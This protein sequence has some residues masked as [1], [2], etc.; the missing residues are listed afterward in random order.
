M[1]SRWIF[2]VSLL[3]LSMHVRAAEKDAVWLPEYVKSATV[4]SVNGYTMSFVPP[5][6]GHELIGFA[7]VEPVRAG[8]DPCYGGIRFVN[9]GDRVAPVLAPMVNAPLKQHRVLRHPATNKFLGVELRAEAC[10]QVKVETGPDELP[11][12]GIRESCSLTRVN[13]TSRG[14]M[15]II[16][17]DDVHGGVVYVIRLR[18]ELHP[19]LLP[20]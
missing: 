19:D 7:L 8:E 2:A 12:S 18:C 14:T 3:A 10:K 15:W 6:K 1:F 9:K 5:G 11:G 4:E 20:Q 17:E 13:I 16:H